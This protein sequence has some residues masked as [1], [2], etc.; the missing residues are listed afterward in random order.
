[1]N[2]GLLL[3][4]QLLVGVGS[5]CTAARADDFSAPAKDRLREVDLMIGTAGSDTL[6]SVTRPF[7][8]TQW[9]PVTS[10]HFV[11][12]RPYHYGDSRIEGFLG[13]HQ[14]AVWMGDYGDVMLVP[15]V[16]PVTL[17]QSFP[18]R[19]EDESSAPN[20]YRVGMQSNSGK[21]K[22]E[23]AAGEHS[24]LM[25][26][27]FPSGQPPF[28]VLEAIHCRD[29]EAT[30]CP[31]I[32]GGAEID[33][34][35]R[36][37]VGRNPDR[38]SYKLGPALAH[39]AGYFVV[40]FDR[41]FAADV[42][43]WEGDRLRPGVKSVGGLHAGS[44]VTFPPGTRQV[45]VRVGTSF[46]SVDQARA[47]LQKE[48]PGWDLE[49]LAKEGAAQ[50][51]A[52]LNRVAVEG[53]TPEQR[54]SFYTALTRAL[55]YPR[56]FSEDG[57]YY[58]AFDDR[59]H[60]GDSYNDFS[61]WDTF[62]A[63]HPLLTLIAPERDNDMVKALVQM[64]EEGGRLPL[65]P[66]PTETNI[67]IS[68]HADCVIADAFVKGL[69]GYD[70]GK[71]YAAVRKDAFVPPP[72]DTTTR[73]A[74]RAP[75]LGPAAPPDGVGFESRGGLTYYQA[76]GY[77]PYDKTEESVSRTVDFG[78]DDYC[79]AQMAKELAP[80]DEA[81]LTKRSVNYRNLFN[82]AT[83]MLAPRS[84]SGTWGPDPSAGFTEGSPW[85]Y[86]FGAMHD[87]VGMIALMGGPERFS[88]RLDE[89][90][91]RGYYVHDNEPGHHYA[92]LYDYAGRPWKTQQRVR[93]V[94][95]KQYQPTPEGLKGDDDCGQMSAWYV[96][97]ALGLYPVTPA[98]GSYALA[99]PIFDRATLYFDAPYHRGRFTI[100]ARG[101][102]PGN[103]YIQSA[104]LNGKP[105][106]GPFIEHKDLVA[107]DGVLEITLGPKPNP[108]LW[109]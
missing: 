90:F 64:Y 13:T 43:S 105:L 18:F 74:D 67:M 31:G 39:F 107:G 16:G 55:L 50:W 11:G 88:S 62:R 79:A 60:D 24:A 5:S 78:V 1:M 45:S 22:T 15:G 81:I 66:N 20:L 58:S 72:L 48:I 8:F 71:A 84:S 9:T 94:M 96:F 49:A 108:G 65:W 41:D 27:S 47:N 44:Y 2:P 76:L 103:V 68:A 82:S 4:F 95:E 73:W 19:H 17:G 40:Q 42:G 12:K 36:E 56:R 102:A 91:E 97:S 63:E 37:I 54:R 80:E 57:R 106:A 34:G 3:I 100:V 93:A 32:P 69:R 46:I 23:I 59:V 75:W 89:N 83:G 10:D 51:N 92:Y 85:T 53:G 35:R 30:S 98:S 33:P 109:R 7:G 99:S 101:Q 104:A 25:R 38:Q 6:P 70:V 52:L 61:L 21:I 26:F 77:V 29:F 14:P 28:F 87:P 86:L